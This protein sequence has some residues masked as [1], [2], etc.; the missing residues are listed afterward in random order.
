MTHNNK[1]NQQMRLSEIVL[2]VCLL[3]ATTCAVKANSI[4]STPLV[5]ALTHSTA[6][7]TWIT[8]SNSNTTIRWGPTGP[9]YANT[10]TGSPSTTNTRAHAWFLSGLQPVTTYHFSV[11]SSDGA[12][13]V[14]SSDQTFVTLEKGDPNPVPPIEI[15]VTMPPSG[16]NMLSVGANCDHPT[17]GLLARWQQANWGD[18][19]V[20]PVTTVCT[21]N[22]IFP[23]KAADTQTPHRWIITQS[24]AADQLPPPGSRVNPKTDADKFARIQTNIPVMGFYNNAGELPEACEAGGYG[25]VSNDSR[26]FKLQQCRPDFPR[27]ITGG[28]GDGVFPIV[29]TVPN[30]GIS[31]NP[32]VHVDSLIGTNTNAKG[33][34]QAAA[35]DANH[36]QLNYV[37]YGR[38]W[39]GNGDIAGG[40]LTRNTW[41]PVPFTTGSAPPLT[42]NVGDWFLRTSSGNPQDNTFRCLEPNTW[43]PFSLRGAFST[44]QAAA[45]TLS[46]NSA[47]YLRFIGLEVT[48]IR[49]PDEPLWLQMSRD[50]YR[51]QYGSVFLG[52]VDQDATNSH[53]IWDRCW[54]HGYVDR[55]RNFQG[56]VFDGDNV[57][58]VDSYLDGF[59][60]W[61]GVEPGS[62]SVDAES[63]AIYIPSGPGPLLL[64]NNYLEAGGITVYVPSDWCCG[65][66]SEPSDGIVRRNTFHL[67]D[68][69]RYG[70]S[71]F[72]GRQVLMRHLLELKQG[73]RWLI[74][75]NIFDGTFTTINQAAAIA[76]TPRSDRGLFSLTGISGGVATFSKLFGRCLEDARIGDW[77]K[78][79]GASNS[80]HET[81]FQIN[82]VSSDSC[83]VGLD[84]VPGSS[85]G[86]FIQLMTNRKTISDIDVRNNTFKNVA[87]GLFI[88]GHTDNSNEPSIQLEGMRRIRIHNNLF[89]YIDGT[90]GNKSDTSAYPNGLGGYTVYASQGMED[91][92][93]THNTVVASSP[94][95]GFALEYGNACDINRSCNPHSGLIYENNIIVA[96]NNYGAIN[97]S[98]TAFGQAALDQL[99]RSGT[100]PSWS[101]RNNV[102]VSRGPLPVQP[103]FGP[104][105]NHNMHHDLNNAAV[106]YV[107]L[108]TDDFR[109]SSLYKATS[110]CF[111]NDGDCSSDGNDVGVNADE[112][113][114]AQGLTTQARIGRV[115]SRQA[116]VLAN[117]YKS[118]VCSAE[119][120]SDSFATITQASV[121]GSGRT[122][123]FWFDNLNPDT[124]YQYRARCRDGV[125]TTGRFRTRVLGPDHRFQ[126]RLKPPVGMAVA[127]A[128]LYTGSSPANLTAITSLP[129]GSGCNFNLAAPDGVLLYYRVEY[130]RSS[131]AVVSA[132][133]IRAWAP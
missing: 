120:S 64:D 124:P 125:F 101:Y 79:T 14:C 51:G 85:T 16:G 93:F 83:T 37:G 102:I 61:A 87:N 89:Q 103:P 55:S 34:F 10:T 88:I 84:G 35:T 60:M 109:L 65:L 71:T 21:G 75:G 9:P 29:V 73:R 67:G 54:I 131:N 108:D 36:I 19:V 119:A 38:Q 106:P 82:S 63:S 12:S 5:D 23:A 32:Y 90:R 76:L 105:P 8:S 128:V 72:A 98:S 41:Q 112:L 53:I 121:L 6:R 31:G 77:V 27:G 104:S 129:C 115:G 18:T 92:T 62:M 33:T 20:I 24:S 4:T 94:G 91:L 59:F 17:S 49:L 117:A 126:L 133:P 66:P 47:R 100:Q 52:L 40:I 39:T 111:G 46:T 56:V 132:G 97:A 57:A 48:S 69:Y 22:Y 58:I 113:F 45:I 25:W 86:G 110:N 96:V 70:S 95:L 43:V 1:K 11:C 28:T 3:G 122:R 74:E 78:V 80:A 30:H 2:A 26:P 7:I 118:G 123:T 81:G 107:S 114:S 130:R 44:K 15:D 13:E 127:N 68:E 50:P 116:S 99:W 42:C